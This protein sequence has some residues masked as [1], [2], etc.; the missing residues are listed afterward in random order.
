MFNA[1]LWNP[2][3]LHAGN[4]I[5][6]ACGIGSSSPRIFISY[7]RCDTTPIADQLFDALHREGFEVFLDRFSIEPG[8]D[9]Q[10]RLTEELS[11]MGF[12]LVLESRNIL[13]SQ[14]KNRGAV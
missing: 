10:V 3:D 14:G 1:A 12:I 6:A 2:G 5:L 4:R 9:F 7:V 11:H 13:S 8:A